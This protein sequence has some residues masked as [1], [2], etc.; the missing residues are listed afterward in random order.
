MQLWMK[1]RT[2]SLSLFIS[3]SC[4]HSSTRY[5]LLTI[6]GLVRKHTARHG[7][8]GVRCKWL[9]FGAVHLLVQERPAAEHGC[10]HDSSICRGWASCFPHWRHPVQP[11]PPF[12]QLVGEPL[13]PPKHRRR[14][15]ATRV[16]SQRGGQGTQRV[17]EASSSLRATSSPIVGLTWRTL[18]REVMSW[19]S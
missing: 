9:P 10:A 2:Q 1:I 17:P 6:V 19:A 7:E 15:W 3:S 12:H 18:A 8:G 14:P 5:H 16:R 13:R 11:I 4:S